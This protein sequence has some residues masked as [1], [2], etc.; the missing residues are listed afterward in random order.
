MK[1]IEIPSVL[2]AL[3]SIRRP[4]GGAGERMAR[5]VVLDAVYEAGYVPV[6]DQ[7]GNIEV[8]VG[9]RSDLLFTAHLDTVHRTDGEQVL[10]YFEDTQEIGAD[11]LDGKASVLGADD[12]AGVY[13]LT[14]MIKAGKPGKYLFF[15]G[16]ECGGIGSSAYVLDHPNISALMCVSF[17]RRG[18]DDIITHQGFFQT[19]SNTFALALS[20]ALNR[21]YPGVFKYEPCDGG[22]Y[23]DSKEFAE[24]VPECTNI[25][26][27]YDHE[28]TVKE[29]QDL[30]HLLRLRDAVIAVDWEA[31]PI[32]RVPEPD[33]PW[34]PKD[35][36][37]AWADYASD[38]PTKLSSTQLRKRINDFRDKAWNEGL[39]YDD[40][41]E[42]LTL[43][44]NNV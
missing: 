29:S 21:C 14:E 44:E 18:T 16:E 9:G 8:Q 37:G 25:S 15:V 6:V 22:L 11:G 17:D 38:T 35:Y 26:V 36:P 43:L 31:L 4:H 19:A 7:H 5:I 28:H 33:T 30:G 42:F 40:L 32:A 27:G 34:W 2:K 20:D 13:L 3:L 1:Q 41:D 10:W 23:T 39:E 12:A 24:L